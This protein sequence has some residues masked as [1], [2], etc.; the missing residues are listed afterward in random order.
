[1][2]LILRRCDRS[3]VSQATEQKSGIPTQL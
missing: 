1:M 2:D 3:G